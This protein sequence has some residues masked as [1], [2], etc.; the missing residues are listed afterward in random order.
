MDT[1]RDNV[2][3]EVCEEFENRRTEWSFEYVYSL[4]EP[5]DRVGYM[6]FYE[7]GQEDEGDDDDNA[8]PW[9]D[10]D[11]PSDPE[12]DA[13]GDTIDR[14]CVATDMNSD[15]KAEVDRHVARLAMLD[16]ASA[17]LD[18]ADAMVRSQISKTIATMRLQIVKE[19]SG[20]SQ[21]DSVVARAVR[22][23]EEYRRDVCAGLRRDEQDRHTR[24]AAA[25]KAYQTALSALDLRGKEL[26]RKEQELV[27]AR[28]QETERIHLRERRE[29]IANAMQ[30]FTLN[31][32]GVGQLGGGGERMRKNRMDLLLSIC[33]L[34]DERP[35][36]FIRNWDRWTRRYDA[37]GVRRFTRA[38]ATK[39]RNDMAEILPQLT[40]GDKR[41]FFK[42]VTKM[43]RAWHLESQQLLVPSAAVAPL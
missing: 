24:V 26:A 20:K 31:D 38:W 8:A 30:G 17:S 33:R 25:E 39:F 21:M 29:E 5:F 28:V 4:L 37:E 7:E 15:Q 42:Y 16:R 40:G 27:D 3:A 10:R 32:L 41:A 6:D 9:D 43:N 19:S 2:I 18:G 1:C 11:A 34:G 13:D 35:P 12:S 36:E 14:A 23:S 22:G